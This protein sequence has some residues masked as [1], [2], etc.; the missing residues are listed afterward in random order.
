MKEDMEK[1]DLGEMTYDEILQ[2]ESF[3]KD[4]L[5]P[6]KRI[7]NYTDRSINWI[8]KRSRY[9]ERKKKKL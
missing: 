9:L 1:V 3:K 6:E 5:S 2:W 7:K 4:I 8:T